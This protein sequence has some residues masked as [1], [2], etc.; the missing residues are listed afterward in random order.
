MMLPAV[1]TCRGSG[2]VAVGSRSVAFHDAAETQANARN[3]VATHMLLRL[4][5]RGAPLA[6][7]LL[8]HAM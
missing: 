1:E 7:L 3:G 2:S 8:L 4:L 5:R 6:R